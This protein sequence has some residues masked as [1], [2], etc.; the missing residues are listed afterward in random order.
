MRVGPARAAIRWLPGRWRTRVW[1]PLAVGLGV[2]LGWLPLFGVL[3]FE[4]ATAAAL[5][6][7]IMGLDVGSARARVR[8]REPARAG[9]AGPTMIRASLA[10][11]GT[12]VAIASVPAGIAVIR[13]IWMPTCDW[14]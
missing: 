6:A 12:A 1:V 3:G 14:G 13:G 9:Y 2:G 10:A 8:Q 5:F 4:L 11:A 7:A